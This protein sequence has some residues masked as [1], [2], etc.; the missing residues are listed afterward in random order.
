MDIKNVN[1]LNIEEFSKNLAEQARNIL[2]NDLTE[3][4]KDYVINKVHNFCL[5]AG[6]ALNHDKDLYLTKSDISV[7]VQLIG[8]W[9]FHKNID[10]IR[11]K[12]PEEWWDPVLKQVAFSVFETGKQIE[13]GKIEHDKALKMIEDVVKFTYN[14]SLTELAENGIIDE[15]DIPKIEAISNIEKMAEIKSNKLTG[16]IKKIIIK[17]AKHLFNKI[18]MLTTY[19]FVVFVIFLTV[20]VFSLFVT[21]GIPFIIKHITSILLVALVIVA[22]LKGLS[23]LVKRDINKQLKKLE[24]VKQQ[25]RDLVDPNKMYCRLGYRGPK[26]L[27]R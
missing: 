14:K 8:K 6:N 5:L 4:Q 11:I 17:T 1:E 13:I 26:K 12:I 20:Y 22:G 16:N 27:D 3:Y 9:T 19:I 21:N 2:P 23:I 24:Q 18:L 10:L 25:M 15:K 7:I